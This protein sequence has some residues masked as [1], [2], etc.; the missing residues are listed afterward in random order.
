MDE[1]IELVEDELADG[2]IWK[3]EPELEEEEPLVM[4]AAQK[5]LPKG[6]AVKPSQFTEYA[7]QLPDYKSATGFK[8]FSFDSGRHMRRIYD[9]PAKRILLCCG[10][11]VGK[12][13]L[14]GNIT[15]CYCCMVTSYRALY[16]SASSTQAKVFSNDRL[17]EPIETSP[18]LKKFTTTMLSS[19]I[20]E[21]QFVNRSKITLRYAYL[22]ADRCVIGTTRVHFTDGTVASVEEVYRNQSKFAGKSVWAAN[23]DT[24]GVESA[25]LLGAVDQGMREVAKVTLCGGTVTTVTNNERFL[26]WAGWKELKELKVGD[27]VAVPRSLPHGPGLDAP[28]EEFRLVAYLLGDGCTT[29][30]NGVGLINSNVEL[31]SDFQRCVLAVGAPLWKLC[32]DNPKH[33]V[34][35]IVKV[36]KFG[37]GKNGYKARLAFLGLIG[38]YSYN[39]HVPPEFF[40][41]N[42]E[43]IRNFL[44]A[45]YSTDG[46]ASVHSSKRL[47]R[48][49]SRQYEIGYCS[50]SRQLLVDIKQLL[51]RFGIFSH[52]SKQKKPS[53]KNAKGSYTLSIRE[54]ENTIRFCRRIGI[55]FKSEALLNVYK[56]AKAVKLGKDIST[57]I[58]FS[59]AALR[60]YLKDKYGLSTHTAWTKHRIQL[61]PGNRKDSI[62]CIVLIRIAKKLNDAWLKA[63]VTSNVGWTCIESIIPDGIQPT[64]D[65]SVERLENYL[66][67]GLF[68]HN[69]RGIPAY[70][71]AIDEFQDILSDNI[72]IIEQCLFA[73][74]EELRRY[75]Y[76][77]TPKSL[78]NNM[79]FLRSQKSTQGEWVVPCDHHIPR[80][81]NILGEKNLGKHGLICEKCRKPLDSAHP[82]AQWAKMVKHADFESYRIPQLIAPTVVWSDVMYHYE[83]DSRQKFYNE[84]LGISYDSGLRPL[85]TEQVRICC[86]PDVRMIDSKNYRQLSYAQ[87]VFAGLDYGSGENSYTVLVLATYV[88][89][90]F[91]VFFVHR[92]VGEDVDPEPQLKKLVELLRY[93]NVKFIGAD[94]GGGFDR[95]DHLVR[96]FGAKRVWKYQYL[97]RTRKK[98]EWDSK[99]GRFKVH[100]TEVMS[101]VFNAIKRKQLEFPCWEEFNQPYAQ[102][103]LNIYSDYNEALRM[104]QYAHRQ[105]KPDDT[106][107]AVLY[108]LLVS[109]MYRARPDILTPRREDSRGVQEPVYSGPIDQGSF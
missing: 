100:R 24:N 72:P 63:M 42:K 18:I 49:A 41:G 9:T 95:N 79:E 61:R 35:E 7:F 78:D 46:W 99:L 105:D 83:T 34:N 65:L 94:Y 77:G 76:S 52:I 88:D 31:M 81:W 39:K 5:A 62:S 101:D 4:E 98:V 20:L 28:L 108:A 106:F 64:Y 57:R 59:Y 96:K 92:F 17:R 27:Y 48:K 29:T 37:G 23:P 13:T 69:C 70:L 15:L 86:N 45:I 2:E 102:D 74:P 80:H 66:T 107:H 1:D 103:M 67:D 54:R 82:D 32:N 10:R 89:S 36:Q 71:L 40:K 33:W 11:Q 68:L 75:I 21:K 26:T 43:Q 97:A 104:I 12:S 109:M 22:N 90:K 51:S 85:T 16:V 38:K 56:T 53:T 19:N 91:R 50:N 55:L 25:A 84:V 8:K 47:G 6:A 44:A 93:F 58:P 87:P 14:I 73:S 60:A 30:K 3:P